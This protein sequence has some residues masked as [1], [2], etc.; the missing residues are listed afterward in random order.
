MVEN[1]L[2]R[3]SQAVPSPHVGLLL[4]DI[5]KSTRAL[6]APGDGLQACPAILDLLQLRQGLAPLPRLHGRGVTQRPCLT[7]PASWTTLL[8]TSGHYT[9][10]I[11]PARP[12]GAGCPPTCKKET[13]DA[14]RITYLY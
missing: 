6:Q 14:V 4:H 10:T 12:P 7:P 13:P 1:L 11:R 5:R 8:D 3:V 9:S 2:L